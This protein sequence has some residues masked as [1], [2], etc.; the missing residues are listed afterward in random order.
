MAPL[1]LRAATAAD[2]PGVRALFAATHKRELSEEL[3]RWRYHG[4][5]DS[6]SVCTVADDGG[7]VAHIGALTSVGDIPRSTIK[8]AL[9]TDLMTHPARRDLGL[10]MDLAQTNLD[11]CR[12]AGVG[13]VYAFPNDR[14][15]PLLKRLFGF[16]D[17]GDL[18][19]YEAPLASLPLRDAPHASQTRPH[20]A[21]LDALWERSA[22]IGALTL[23]RDAAWID[24][25]FHRR[26]G[27]PYA[28]FYSRLGELLSGWAAVKVFDGPTGRVGDIVELW[29]DSPEAWASL[30][31]TMLQW[32]AAQGADVVSAWAGPS[33][34]QAGHYGE[35]G[36]KPVGPR[37][38]F[39]AKALAPG[40]EPF[41][42]GAGYWRI[43]KGD[44]DV[45]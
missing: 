17:L 12:A 14:S 5:P 13:L 1:T 39:V 11:A 21:E 45:F 26:P 29:G 22:P 23:R 24:W 4:R 3:W 31:A 33:S 27:A 2:G 41:T 8:L 42:G 6:P 20:S 25:R 19:A 38:H 30:T 7:V 10:F 35:M 16:S 34:A 40:G 37:T 32:F 43:G 18:A 44:S 15:Y 28:V 9:W 36:L